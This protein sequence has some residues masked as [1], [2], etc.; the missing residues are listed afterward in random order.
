LQVLLV[1]AVGVQID[2]ELANLQPVTGFLHL[3]SFP[4]GPLPQVT[5]TIATS[6]DVPD[7]VR[8]FRAVATVEAPD[9]PDAAERGEAGLRD[10]LGVYDFLNS[11]TCFLLLARVYGA[12]LAPRPSPVDRLPG[13]AAAQA[14]LANANGAPA[15]YLLAVRIPKADARVGFLFVD[16][17]YVLPAYRRMG[18]ARALL[19]RVQTLSVERGLAGVRLLV[20]EENLGA[21]WLYQG[22]G[23]VEHSTLFCEWRVEQGDS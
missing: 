15:G 7:L 20:R 19:E 14:K 17:V 2:L 21:R 18:V 6:H 5:V 8:F 23:F 16:E 13:E 4:G 11:D 3:A 1:Q 22:C 12:P 9:N 10:A